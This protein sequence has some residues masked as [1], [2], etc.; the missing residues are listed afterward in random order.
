MT[1]GEFF[2]HQLQ[3]CTIVIYLAGE[4]E[5]T[6]QNTQLSCN[7]PIRGP[8]FSVLSAIYFYILCLYP[9]VYH[10]TSP[11]TVVSLMHLRGA[12]GV[13]DVLRVVMQ[14]SRTSRRPPL[15]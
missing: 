10:A 1:P 6:V 4:R 15:R 3:K 7:F 2:F 14:A 8:F 11:I 12:L 9:L 13:G 5:D